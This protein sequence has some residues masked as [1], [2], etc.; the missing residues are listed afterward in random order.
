MGQRVQLQPNGIGGEAAAGQ[1]VQ[2]MVPSL[3]SLRCSKAGP[4]MARL[5]SAAR[6]VAA[7]CPDQGVR[8]HLAEGLALVVQEL[9]GVPE[10]MRKRDGL[11][12]RHW[13]FG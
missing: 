5:T 10:A 1:P 9:T 4:S 13:P 3:S 6:S 7:A 11:Y 12:Q 8:E 2:T